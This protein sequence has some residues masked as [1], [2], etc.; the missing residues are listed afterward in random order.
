MDPATRAI[1]LYEEGKCKSLRAAAKAVGA[2]RSTVQRR[3]AGMLPRHQTDY[4]LARLSRLQER[5]LVQY[6]LDLQSQYQPPNQSQIHQM[7]VQLARKKEPNATL[8]VNWVERFLNRHKS[9]ATRR[10]RSFEKARIVASIPQMLT[11]WYSHINEVILRYK[12]MPK[13]IHNIDEIGYQMSHSQ[14]EKVV[15]SRSVGA[16]IAMASGSTGWVSVLECISAA[17]D[18]LNPLLI[19]RG[20]AF[21]KPLDC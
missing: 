16:L 3:Y 13:D 14:K 21:N 19:H 7:A 10:N 11:G 12:I 2:A 8:G 9:L 17:S 18:S 15:F 5:V 4:K 20:K 6:I 1:T